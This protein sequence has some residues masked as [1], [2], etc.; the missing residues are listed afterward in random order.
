MRNQNPQQKRVRNISL[1]SEGNNIEDVPSPKLEDVKDKEKP[2]INILLAYFK[3][4]K[5]PTRNPSKDKSRKNVIIEEATDDIENVVIDAFAIGK[6]RAYDRKELANSVNNKK[7]PDLLLLLDRLIKTHNPRFSY[8]TIQINKGV[9]TTFHRDKG[10]IGLSYCIGLGDFDGGG[11]IIRFAD[12]VEKTYDNHNKWLY[13]DGH[14]LEHASNKVKKG[15]RYA[16]I[17]F[18]HF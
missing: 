12:G 1:I 4:I 8:T 14:S 10:N 6:V 17:Y 11:I 18:T 3:N 16:V 13:Y 7:F 15:L 2:L 5:F 9:Q